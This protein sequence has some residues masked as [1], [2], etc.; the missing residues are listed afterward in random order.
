MKLEVF[1]VG[2]IYK[3]NDLRI[4]IDNFVK[5]L[6]LKNYIMTLILVVVKS[7]LSFKKIIKIDNFK[8]NNLNFFQRN[9]VTNKRVIVRFD[10]NV[11]L[12]N[13]KIIDDT[14]IKWLNLF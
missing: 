9:N 4:G 11:P 7:F 10:P 3:K 13:G 14:R 5:A 12:K 8:M 6:H 2:E 1:L